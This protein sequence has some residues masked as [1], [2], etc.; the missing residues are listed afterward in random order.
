M[1]KKLKKLLVSSLVC[2]STL[3]VGT[4]VF[5]KYCSGSYD[6]YNYSHELTSKDANEGYYE[7]TANTRYDGFKEKGYTAYAYV[8]A[9]NSSG[10]V[11]SGSKQQHYAANGWASVWSRVKNPSKW[12]STH[13]LINNGTTLSNSVVTCWVYK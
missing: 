12:H 1:D 5:A 7:A 11:I 2:V 4:N 13:R 10:G 9:V 6:G 3:S 8:E